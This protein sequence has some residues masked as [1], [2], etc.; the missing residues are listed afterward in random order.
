M[1][2]NSNANGPLFADAGGGTLRLLMYLAAALI[3]MVSDH[4][5]GFLDRTRA[6]AR[7]LA[8]PL[9]WVASSPVR[10][11]RDFREGFVARRE[12]ADEAQ[13]LSSELLVANA[14][15][16]RLASVQQENR[17]LRDLLDASRERRLSV[18]LAS[19]VDVD[20]DPFRHRVMLDAGESAGVRTG[21]AIIDAAGVMGQVIEVSPL[22]STA[23]LIS[24]PSHA[25]PVQVVRSGVR[26][27]AYGT[28]D[29]S[30]LRLPNLPPSADVRVDDVL[31]TSGLGG[32]F[33]A[34]FPVG[35][36]R[37]IAPDQTRMFLVAEA[38]PAAALSRSGEVL[39][40][41]TD[42]VDTSTPDVDPD[43]DADA[44]EEAGAGEP[45][46]AQPESA[47]D[48]DEASEDAEPPPSRGADGALPR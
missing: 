28:G 27:V 11:A 29:T 30:T 48:G 4:R 36:I 31:V 15:L 35:R 39:L 7:L 19:L 14:R 32:T 26:T 42:V 18:Q 10:F 23:M 17:R 20:L 16:R 43:A 44:E 33:P 34:G 21:L 9:Y 12:L 3:L 37:E 41:W 2:L 38:E 5:A 13:R 25:I 40:V 6:A 22:S 47:A 8:E 24:D 45:H 1:A 46:D